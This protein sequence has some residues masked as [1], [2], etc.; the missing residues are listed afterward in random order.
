MALSQIYEYF[1]FGQLLP[2]WT[3]KA[4]PKYIPNNGVPENSVLHL[5]P[6]AELF[7]YYLTTGK[8]VQILYIMTHFSKFLYGV[9]SSIYSHVRLTIVT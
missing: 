5:L 1:S 7:H 9:V 2:S 4:E 8:A 3:L 6:N